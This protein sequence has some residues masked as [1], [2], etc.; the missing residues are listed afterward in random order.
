[1]IDFDALV[2]VPTV[3]K[4][5]GEPVT[6]APASGASSFVVQ[7]VYDKGYLPVSPVGGEEILSRNP[8]CG[9]REKEFTDQTQALPI[10]D[11]L[12]T[13]QR[14]GEVYIVRKPE[15]DGQGHILLHLNVFSEEE[16]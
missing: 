5:F 12:L 4:I 13:I 16:D 14:T 6:Y 8:V 10:Q 1:M 15:R 7:G 2:L 9:V 11:D 3:D